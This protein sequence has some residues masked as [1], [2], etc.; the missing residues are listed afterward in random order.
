[1]KSET[2]IALVSIIMSGAVSIFTIVL[3]YRTARFAAEANERAKRLEL[4]TPVLYEALGELTLSFSQL[5]HVQDSRSIDLDDLRT[6]A[7]KFSY[8]AYRLASLISDSN[9]QTALLSLANGN[10][11]RH[12]IV[13]E[14]D[15]EEFYAVISQLSDHLS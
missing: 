11:G 4:K 6:R 14:C 7:E 15:R 10:I 1:M 9:M 3:N 8:A 12:G 2:V 13:N 5:L